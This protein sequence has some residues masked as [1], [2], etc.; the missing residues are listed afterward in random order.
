[1]PSTLEGAIH[2]RGIATG[3]TRR[4]EAAR[5]LLTRRSE[6]VTGWLMVT[7]WIVG[8]LVFTLG[9]M[10]ASLA[11]SFTKWPLLAT[12]KWIGLQ[13]YARM[14]SKDPLVKQALKVS[15]IYAVSAVPLN[16]VVGLIV[17]LL[18]NQDIKALALVRTIY[19][20]PSCVS[21]VAVA[22]V[23]VQILAG[24]YG[25]LNQVLRMVGIQGPY[26]LSDMRTV[27]PAFVLMSLW[28]VGGSVII[29]LAGLQGI[30]TDLYE[31]ADVDGAGEWTKFRHITIPMISPVLFFQLVMGIIGSL[32]VFAGPFIMTQGGPNN[33]SLFYML[34]LYQNAFSFFKMGY[35]SALAWVLFIY[36][37]VL[38]LF[39]FRSSA[40]WVFYAGEIKGR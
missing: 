10:V 20:L 7:P 39:V 38:T 25:L 6:W 1:M 31:A 23:W 22:L 13:N 29:Y 12:P 27:L 4:R 2:E 32:Q 18:L 34:Y 33:A 8:F 26:W 28:G 5:R 3:L 30:P 15:T 14:I 35:A 16:I 37:M 11:L 40:L 24:D 17:A 19:Y 36:I 21:G 9:P